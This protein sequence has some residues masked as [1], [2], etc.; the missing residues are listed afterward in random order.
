[1]DVSKGG[2]SLG[3]PILLAF[4]I[5]L[6]TKS[7]K[8]GL[9]VVGGITVGGSLE[10]V[11]NAVSVSELAVERGAQTVMFPVSARRQLNDLSDTMA[12]RIVM[13][14]YVDARDA[15]LKVLAD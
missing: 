8:G 9:V 4:C 13:V 15:L 1:M 6:L 10:P 7:L 14:Y 3:V 12:A 2:A 5:V 11:H